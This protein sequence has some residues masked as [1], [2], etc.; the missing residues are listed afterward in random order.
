M[1]L[2]KNISLDYDEI[3]DMLYKP[4]D[5]LNTDCESYI[6]EWSYQNVDGYTTAREKYSSG[7]PKRAEKLSKKIEKVTVEKEEYFLSD[8]PADMYDVGTYLSGE[9]EYYLNTAMIETAGTGKT[10]K[11]FFCYTCISSNVTDDQLFNAAKDIAERII[12]E[13]LNGNSIKVILRYLVSNAYGEYTETDIT[14]KESYS[15]LDIDR[16]AFVLTN[17][18]FLRRIVFR[19]WEEQPIEIRK[20]FNWGSWGSYGTPLRTEFI[21]RNYS[22]TGDTK[23][24]SINL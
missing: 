17:S 2:Y 5:P 20:R 13:E 23:H 8:N 15:A 3:K 16:L 22:D 1:T 6:D 19:I 11:T 10:V 12:N 21:K 18:A 14:I 4:Y 9:P 24:I 7:D